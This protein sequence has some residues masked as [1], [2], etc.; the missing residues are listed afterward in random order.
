MNELKLYFIPW[1]ELLDFLESRSILLVSLSL[2]LW[3]LVS[4][5]SL[6]TFEIVGLEIIDALCLSSSSSP[7]ISDTFTMTEGLPIS[8]EI[9]LL[10]RMLFK[11][12][13]WSTLIDVELS[14]SSYSL[15]VC[16]SMLFLRGETI[17]RLSKRRLSMTCTLRQ[18]I[19]SRRAIILMFSSI[20]LW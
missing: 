7:E 6:E 8:V 18:D 16:P 5:P 15:I 12:W 19:I 13:L 4:L 14:A 10:P 3:M 9:C 20:A 17:V 1:L 2:S 11:C